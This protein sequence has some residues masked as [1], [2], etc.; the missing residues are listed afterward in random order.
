MRSS[1][2]KKLLPRLK[3][4]T[5]LLILAMLSA[6]ISISLTLLIPVLVGRA[7]D[8]I[9]AEG[10]VYFE[11]VAQ[12]IIYIAAAVIGVTSCQWLMNFLVNLISFRLVRDL[13]RDVFRKFNTVPLSAI[14]TNPH[15]D[16]ISRVINDVDAVGDGLTQLI[17]Q[18]FSGVVTIVGT[19]GFML[20]IDWRIA[21]AVFLLTPMSLFLA[22][23]IGRLTHR[24]F[25]EQQILQGEISSFVEEHVGNQRLVKAFSFEHRAFE[26]FDKYNDELQTVGFKA[27]FA[28]ALANPST[29][30]VNALVYAAVGVFGAITVITGGLS[31]GGLSCFLTYA[32]QYTKPF[33]EVTGVLTQL[34]TGIAAAERIFEVLEWA[35]ETPDKSSTPLENCKGS[36]KIEDVSFSYVPEKPLIKHF[37]LDVPSGCHV[38]I[39]GPTGCGKTT[40]INLLMRFYEVNEGRI[41]LDGTDIR[42]LS[43]DALRRCY[44]MVLQDSWLFCG[45]IMENLRYGNENATDDEVIA[46]AKSAHAHSFIKRMPNGYDTEISEGGGNLSQGQKQLLCIARAMLTNPS[47]LILDEATSSIDTLT[48]I[49]VQKAFAK[50]MKGRTSFV[51]AH[52]L[53]TIKESDVILVMKDGNI[54]EQGNHEELLKKG[55]FYHTLYHS[56][57]ENK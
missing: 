28:G 37:S 12:I 9:I 20:A 7:I 41:L 57:F 35:D 45:T 48:E 25:T 18:L 32:N 16:L 56:Q 36:V 26:G 13:R 50:M 15:G 30:F 10:Q 54:I 19:L 55:G 23:F 4:H 49:R 47:V 17:L 21:I 8:N 1:A 24:R 40:L 39:V 38:A 29:R 27:Q 22:A 43:R 5:G 34:S 6:V 52:R 44:G 51:V 3:S 53:S 33:N 42:D 31:I 46:A 2:V 14:D 11:A